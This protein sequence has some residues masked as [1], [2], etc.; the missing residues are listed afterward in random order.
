M[1][2]LC[3]H[4]PNLMARDPDQLVNNLAT[5]SQRLGIPLEDLKAMVLDEPGL[6][7]YNASTLTNRIHEVTHVSR[8]AVTRGGW[9]RTVQA[10]A[11]DGSHSSCCCCSSRREGTKDHAPAP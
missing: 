7:N 8:S 4:W 6:L 9:T 11:G 2:R 10:G 1:Q 3:R 5:L